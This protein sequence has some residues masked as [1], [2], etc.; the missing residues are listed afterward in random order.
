[1]CFSRQIWQRKPST[2]GSTIN[3]AGELT[4]D[5]RR[6]GDSRPVKERDEFDHRGPEE[7]SLFSGSR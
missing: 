1:M 6:G 2:Y 5:H 3:Q 7:P 4:T